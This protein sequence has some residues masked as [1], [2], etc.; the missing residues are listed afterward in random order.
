MSAFTQFF[1][2]KSVESYDDMPKV[3]ILAEFCLGDASTIESIDN[4]GLKEAVRQAVGKF[5]KVKEAQ[6]K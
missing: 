6:K 5:C 4:A 3:S 1:E 2:A